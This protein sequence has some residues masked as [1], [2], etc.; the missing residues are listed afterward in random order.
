MMPEEHP[1]GGG[2]EVSAVG[3]P[4]GGGGSPVVETQYPVGQKAAIE[5]VRQEIGAD[6]GQ[7]QPGGADGLAPV[8]REHS[9]GGGTGKGEC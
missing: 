5:T 9:P 2:D 1:A 7:H 4:F 6:R 8:E 3:E